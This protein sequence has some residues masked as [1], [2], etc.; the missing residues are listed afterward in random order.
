MSGKALWLAV[1]Q[2][3]LGVNSLQQQNNH[4]FSFFYAKP[5][6]LH[7]IPD[8]SL[9]AAALDTGV[10]L[11][12]ETL[13]HQLQLQLLITG[14]ETIRQSRQD[15]VKPGEGFLLHRISETTN[16]ESIIGL[17]IARFNL[18]TETHPLTRI[19]GCSVRNVKQIDIIS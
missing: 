8:H 5:L 19:S 16:K 9:V 14:A 13:G 6:T 3:V 17:Y 18:S 11:S 1:S 12:P 7:S 2:A 4:L 15:L 10:P